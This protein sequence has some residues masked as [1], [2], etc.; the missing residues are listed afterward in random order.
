MMVLM[1][2]DVR[3]GRKGRCE[4]RLPYV[5]MYSLC[6]F[7]NDV[8]L[9]LLLLPSPYRLGDLGMYRVIDTS[10]WVLL[11]DGGVAVESISPRYTL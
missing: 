6:T 3:R 8:V 2:F 1:C 11:I 7:P 9:A 4:T 10:A 5:D